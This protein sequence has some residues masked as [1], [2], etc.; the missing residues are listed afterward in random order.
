MSRL[1]RA[2]IEKM[3]RILIVVVV[4]L[5]LD[6]SIIVTNQVAH[7]SNPPGTLYVT[8]TMPTGFLPYP[9]VYN[10]INALS[11]PAVGECVATG[12]FGSQTGSIISTN[13]S[14]MTWTLDA[15]VPG[16]VD[17]V[18]NFHQSLI[19]GIT[20]LSQGVCFALATNTNNSTGEELLYTNGSK[21]LE[22]SAVSITND[23]EE[24]SC[25]SATQCI[26]LGGDGG[27]VITF[28]GSSIST[29]SFPLPDNA[30]KIPLGYDSI[31]CPPDGGTYCIASGVA[32]GNVYTYKI[33]LNGT[34]TTPTLVITFATDGT[35]LLCESEQVCIIDLETTAG[36]EFFVTNDGGSN[37]SA[38]QAG[39]YMSCA[40]VQY[41]ETIDTNSQTYTPNS[42]D[43]SLNFY[44]QYNAPNGPD[45][46]EGV[47]CVQ[48]SSLCYTL[49]GGLLLTSTQILPFYPI[50][51][52]PITFG[53]GSLSV[54]D[55]SCGCNPAQ[56]S[57]NEPINL[58][59]GDY[60][61]TQGK[62][63]L[64]SGGSIPLD[65]QTTYDADSAQSGNSSS[66]GV[67][68][69]SNLLMNISLNTSNQNATV[70]EENGSQTVFTPSTK[71]GSPYSW[72]TGTNYCAEQSSVLA[73]LNHNN[74]GTWSYI[75]YTGASKNETLSFSSGQSPSGVYP[76]ISISSPSGSTISSSPLTPGSGI[77]PLSSPGCT[78]WTS[79]IS[80]NTL[81]LIY[82]TPLLTGEP[83]PLLKL[84][85][86]M[87]LCRLNSHMN[88]LVRLHLNF[89]QIQIV[90]M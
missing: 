7:A 29:Q 67:G 44:T 83:N 57:T 77:C 43:P 74:D 82:G 73:T 51:P 41:C 63:S 19:S 9:G 65:F 85:Q 31:S 21:Y 23:Y 13:N 53:G 90:A 18:G 71:A 89:N 78:N 81:T 46:Y 2:G 42:F 80:G 16:F 66:L 11:C 48:G 68:W 70:T 5:S 49:Y 30:N 27:L 8:A 62:I 25:L 56:P 3:I 45:D 24:L 36:S 37:W 54:A 69:S 15:I 40:T 50:I 86:A 26:V 10:S 61:K 33:N 34:T 55:N 79:N 17:W 59:T 6:N 47:S 58:A 1:W 72:C 64:P 88:Q 28:T 60:Y 52:S 20:C 22:W 75:R 32:S 39:N 84:S 14:G 38:S 87:A 35:V 76:L 12:Y 4:F